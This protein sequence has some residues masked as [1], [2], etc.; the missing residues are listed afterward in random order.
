[1]TGGRMMRLRVHDTRGQNRTRFVVVAL[2]IALGVPGIPTLHSALATRTYADER[3]FANISSHNATPPTGWS[4][5]GFPVSRGDVVSL[6][7]QTRNGTF[8]VS[9]RFGES[10]AHNGGSLYPYNVTGTEGSFK[11]TATSDGVVEISW[12][13][14]VGGTTAVAYEVRVIPNPTGLS[15]VPIFI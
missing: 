9:F 2:V 11:F 1:M 10:L 3:V 8:E 6:N 15:L 7:Y 14:L 4:G 13:P 12:R 5:L